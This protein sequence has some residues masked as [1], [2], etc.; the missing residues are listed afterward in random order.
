M[1]NPVSQFDLH[2]DADSLNGFIENEL[3]EPERA[4][5]IAHLASCSR[6]RQI[7]YLAQD[8][9]SAQTPAPAPI[10]NDRG[11]VREGWWFRRWR[12]AWAPAAAFAMVA[13]VAIFVH[14]RRGANPVE[15]ARGTATPLASSGA[16]SALPAPPNSTPAKALASPP[17]RAT[18]SSVSDSLA[19]TRQAVTS[20]GTA[21]GFQGGIAPSQASLSAPAAAP[22]LPQANADS[23]A[24]ANTESK[25]PP[26]AVRRA[27]A[28]ASYRGP[29][30]PQQAQGQAQAQGQ[31]QG[32][33]AAFNQN[34][35]IPKPPIAGLTTTTVSVQPAPGAASETVE[36]NADKVQLPAEAFVHGAQLAEIRPQMRADALQKEKSG[37]TMLPS[38]LPLISTTE[39]GH[40]ILAID[41]IGA[42]FLSH[43]FG[44]TWERVEQQWKGHAMKV[45]IA[46]P[47]KNQTPAGEFS[48][49]QNTP[50]PA[51]A[52]TVEV[53]FEIVNEHN[54]V[55][56]SVDGK[57]W[58]AKTDPLP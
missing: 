29:N 16:Q 47:A 8:A 38:G 44:K 46:Q 12:F 20:A 53:V 1:I 5:V 14:V 15:V 10:D 33:A 34:A 13:M 57:S 32:F 22:A 41:A 37:L 11:A 30:P 18:A 23:I 39:A 50:P 54:S 42:L 48:A 56:T 26:L 31:G 51:P 49:K 3:R 9:A 40:T 28:G 19:A 4:N 24:Q 27:V 21:E 2:P 52:L 35:Q 17:R 55:W 36:V 6:C 58:T 43:D 7:V 25:S 45:R